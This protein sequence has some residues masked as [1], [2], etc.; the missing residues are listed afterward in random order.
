LDADLAYI[1]SVRNTVDGADAIAKFGMPLSLAEQQQLSRQYNAQDELNATQ[2]AITKA[3]GESFAGLWIDQTR[4]GLVSLGLTG[5]AS[6]S[7]VAALKALME[8]AV[9]S[10]SNIAIAPAE[11]AY[12]ELQASYDALS[13]ALESS[14]SAPSV[15][16]GVGINQASNRVVVAVNGELSNEV[17]AWVAARTPLSHVQLV[18]TP[19]STFKNRLTN[20]PPEKA[21]LGIK[22]QGNP[23]PFE[24]TSGFYGHI[25][26]QSFVLTAG[27]CAGV[28]TGN[29][30][31]GA[32]SPM[33]VMSNNNYNPGGTM[34]GD[35]AKITIAPANVGPNCY[36]VNDATCVNYGGIAT[37]GPVAQ[38]T[39]VKA[40][41]YSG[42][43]YGSITITNYTA[44]VGTTTVD[45]LEKTN[46]CLQ[47]GDS[48][49]TFS[50]GNNGHDNVAFG[51]ESNG[52]ACT[53]GDTGTDAFT[54]WYEILTASGFGTM[55]WGH[56]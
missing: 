36:Y 43:A 7:A 30:Q 3:A 34:H 26:G 39:A 32:S 55:Q 45:H 18:S 50:G 4:G 27:H 52:A 19:P 40:E 14:M 22:P 15:I 13:G 42:N 17:K 8:S 38:G 23:N 12:S 47:P 10:A 29:W 2:D 11:F 31:V 25:G 9:P 51:L 33:G 21:G 37:G 46:A 44:T 48:G 54:P 41:G 5:S 35:V 53:A 28:G 56:A 1:D 6:A 16:N 24:C 20:Y 49:A